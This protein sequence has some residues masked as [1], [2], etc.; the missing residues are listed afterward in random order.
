YFVI[1]LT[2]SLI[3]LADTEHRVSVVNNYIDADQTTYEEAAGIISNKDNYG[4]LCVTFRS[5]TLGLLFTILF[6]LVNQYF[7]YRTLDYSSS[8]PLVLLLIYPLEYCSS[9][10]LPN[11]S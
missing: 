11:W 4:I 3:T 5:L 6:S 9:R 7:Y 2:P 1:L 10:Y 8:L